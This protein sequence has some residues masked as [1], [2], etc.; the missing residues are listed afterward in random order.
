MPDNLP[1]FATTL[2]DAESVI[3]VVPEGFQLTRPG[4]EFR[5]VYLG[6]RIWPKRNKETGEITNVPVAQ[7]YDGQKIR[8]N[9]GVQLVREVDKL[10]PGTSVRIVLVRSEKNTKNG[11]TKIY[12]IFPLRLP[13]INPAA[14]FG[15]YLPAPVV[16][17][18]GQPDDETPF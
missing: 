1:D 18:T 13:L 14:L 10:A 3:S 12:D 8:T 17:H 2:K 7:F 15:G 11:S 16:E 4:E 9:M 5:G 6:Q